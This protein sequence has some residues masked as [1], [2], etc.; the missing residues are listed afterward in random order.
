MTDGSEQRAANGQERNAY[1]ASL[2]LSAYCLP[3]FA[4][5][6]RDAQPSEKT[7]QIVV[8]RKLNSSN[9]YEA[10]RHAGE[11]RQA[12]TLKLLDSGSR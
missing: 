7:P 9:K 8:P 12:I 10:R 6:T 3:F 11:N 1:E 4:N 5:R 2:C